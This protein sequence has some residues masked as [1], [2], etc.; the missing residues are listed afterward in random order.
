MREAGSARKREQ[1]AAGTESFPL[2]AR[3]RRPPRAEGK[4]S[5]SVNGVDA[6]SAQ[7]RAE[8]EAG[9]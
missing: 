3:H 8:Q 1:A 7:R 4:V 9:R 5:I 6:M 2:S